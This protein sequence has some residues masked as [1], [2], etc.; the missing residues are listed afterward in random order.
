MGYSV[1]AWVSVRASRR[2]A[3]WTLDD[4]SAV[5]ILKPLHGR[6]PETYE[7]LRSFCDQEYP[8]FQVVFGV[9]DIDDPALAIVKRLQREFPHRDLRV[10]IDRRQHGS[11][12]KVSN[13]ALRELWRCWRGFYIRVNVPGRSIPTVSG[14]P[15]V[16]QN[17]A[18]I[19]CF[20]RGALLLV[21][22]GINP[23]SVEPACACA[24]FSIETAAFLP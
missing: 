17:W 12:R 19:R 24:S 2:P 21:L 20:V 18:M 15:S 14:D 9:S 22:L 11:N 5:T 10:V 7:C 23:M 8:E 13:I 16:L 3:R 6:E 1:M 4:S